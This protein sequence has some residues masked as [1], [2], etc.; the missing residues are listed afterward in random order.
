[1]LVHNYTILMLFAFEPI[2]SVVPAP[3]RCRRGMICL[4]VMIFTTRETPGYSS[5]STTICE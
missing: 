1:M 2:G 3:T 5:W 4:L